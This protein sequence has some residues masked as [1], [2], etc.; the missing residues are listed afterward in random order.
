M[1]RQH[2]QST[3]I[4]RGAYIQAADPATTDAADLQAR[5]MWLDTSA[6]P[7]Q[8]NKRNEAND[9]WDVLG[10]LGRALSVSEIDANY[11]AA[12][13][14]DVLFVTEAVTIT[15]TDADERTRPLVVKN[16]SAGVVTLDGDGLTIDGAATLDLLPTDRRTLI[17][18]AAGALE[19]I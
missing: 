6:A 13:D 8:I 11:T 14:D 19:T 4:H 7:Y 5:V 9:G 17:P 3:E 16:V 12:D 18:R 10:H 2:A 1:G 15:L